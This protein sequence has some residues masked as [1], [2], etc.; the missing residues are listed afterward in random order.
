MRHKRNAYRVLVGT[1]EGRRALGRP[2]HK[3]KLTLEQ[4]MKVQ[5]RGVEI[6]STISLTVVLDG[7]WVVKTTPPSF[8]PQLRTPVPNVGGSQSHPG[9]KQKIS[10]PLGFNPLTI[11]PIVSHCTKHAILAHKH[12]QK[13]NIKNIS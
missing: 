12:K 7:R 11:W 5:T 4:A 2:R 1:P 10:P 13:D 9:E 6:S 3:W 8:Y